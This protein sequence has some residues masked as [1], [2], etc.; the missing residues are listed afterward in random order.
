MKA[1]QPSRRRIHYRRCALF[2]VVLLLASTPALSQTNKKDTASVKYDPRVSLW[3][4]SYYGKNHGG[5]GLSARWFFLGVGLTVFRFAGDTTAPLKPR[6]GGIGY[7]L[8]SYLVIDITGWLA[9]Y[10]SLGTAGR[11]QTYSEQVYLNP[12]YKE[13]DP[14]AYGCGV[15]TVVASHIMFGIGYHVILPTVDSDNNKNRHRA[16]SS[17]VGQLGWRF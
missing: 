11:F 1:C 13:P 2:L 3:I 7:A 4:N 17:F 14:V 9:A 16:I 6:P 10:G 5:V 12:D 8:D 15:Q